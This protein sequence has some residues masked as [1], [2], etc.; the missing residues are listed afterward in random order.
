MDLF[1]INISKQDYNNSFFRPAHGDWEAEYCTAPASVLQNA[2]QRVFQSQQTYYN[3]ELSSLKQEL[4]L[5]KQELNY[6]KTKIYNTD[7]INHIDINSQEIVRLYNN[8]S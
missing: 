6:I 7:D 5:L 1:K 4:Y 3:E 8:I 2:V